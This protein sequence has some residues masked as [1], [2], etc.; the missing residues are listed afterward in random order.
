MKPMSS[1][2]SVLA[3]VVDGWAVDGVLV[4]RWRVRVGLVVDAVMGGRGVVF[5]VAELAV[6]PLC[7]LFFGRLAADAKMSSMSAVDAADDAGV[8]AAALL[9]LSPAA[10][11]PSA[12]IRLPTDKP[13][14]EGVVRWDDAEV[15]GV[16]VGC[17]SV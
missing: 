14:V 13:A 3:A 7:L 5:A 8:T 12:A 11:T 2:G 4:E 17:D 15:T 16:E 6:F 1:S 9:F 10:A